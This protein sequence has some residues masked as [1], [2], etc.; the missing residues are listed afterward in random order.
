MIHPT[1]QS[2]AKRQIMVF[3]QIQKNQSIEHLTI[4]IAR[5]QY[6]NEYRQL[7]KEFYLKF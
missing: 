1:P 2:A 6:T 7:T 4:E 3:S 5:H